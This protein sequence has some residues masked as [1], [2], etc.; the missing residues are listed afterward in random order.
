MA[1]LSYDGAPIAVR[2][3]LSAAQGLVWDRLGSPGT[4]LDAEHR[5]SVAAET[6]HAAQCHLCRHQKEALSP[7]AIAGKHDSLGSLPDNWVE[8]VHRVMS[9][10]ARLTRS[11]YRRMLEGGISDGE[12]IEIVSVLAHVVAI[13][14][15]ARGLGFPKQPLPAVNSGAPSRYRPA[16]AR[17]HE[18]WVPTIAWNQHGPNEA[19]YF[20][21]NPSNIRIALTLVPDEARSFFDLASH[22]YLPGPAMQDFAQ[23]YRAITHAQIELLAGRVSAI[24]QCTY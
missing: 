17:V 13:D 19:D 16:E 23:E 1:T 12:Y 18:H 9:D 4:W 11:W 24:N 5:I 21:G 15:F 10:P 3:D 2:D 7:Y 22:Q 8:V 20:V 14:T 6:R